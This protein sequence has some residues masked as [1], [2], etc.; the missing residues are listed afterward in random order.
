MQVPTY[1]DGRST[2]ARTGGRGLRRIVAEPER[3][4]RRRARAAAIALLVALVAAACSVGTHDA[5]QEDDL[6]GIDLGGPTTTATPTTIAAAPL[7]TLPEGFVLPDTR[8][9]VLPPVVGRNRGEGDHSR[10]ILPVRGGGASLRGTV[11]GP[12]GPVGGAVVRL[13]RFVGDDFGREDIATNGEGRW[14]ASGLLGGRYKVRAW[15]RPDL[16]TVEPQAAFVSNKDGSATLDMTVE[17]FEGEQL[18]GALDTAEPAVGQIVTLRALVTR[19]EVNEDGIVSGVGLEGREVQLE[20]LGGIRIVGEKKK[21]TD[22]DGFV[23]LSV[24]CMVTGFH[25]VRLRSGDLS[26]DVDLPECLDGTFDAE[27]LP[28]ELPDFPV[29]STFSVPSAGPYPPGTYTATSP[30]NCGTSFQEF[31]G[32]RWAAN[33]SLE[34]SFSPSNP[35]RNLG[36][37]PGRP[38]CTFRRSA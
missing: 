31:I 30:G 24:V 12:D 18:Q 7:V 29:G 19:V 26:T 10:P 14:E 33:V 28:P 25:G 34:R 13:E 27:R 23:E 4:A 6:G 21:T 8:A 17:R 16:A 5:R 35:I 36:S 3:L 2:V 37:V 38:A 15:A 32:D 9:V 22:V 20:V 1:P 11:Y